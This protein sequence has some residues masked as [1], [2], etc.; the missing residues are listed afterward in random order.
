M[1]TELN[2]GRSSTLWP[3][4]ILRDSRSTSQASVSGRCLATV[5]ARSLGVNRRKVLMRTSSATGTVLLC[6]SLCQIGSSQFFLKGGCAFLSLSRRRKSRRLGSRRGSFPNRSD[7]AFFCE[8][9]GSFFDWVGLGSP[10]LPIPST[11][12]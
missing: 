1:G 10:F 5:L 7:F 6:M 11:E 8:L 4:R 12:C 3:Q 9:A 2:L